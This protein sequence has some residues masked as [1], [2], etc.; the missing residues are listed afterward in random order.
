MEPIYPRGLPLEFLA[1]ATRYLDVRF[2]LTL[3]ALAPLAVAAASAQTNLERVVNGAFTPT[4]DYDLVHQRI[5][6]GNFDWDSTSFDGR[7]TT[8]VVSRRPGLDAV[9]LDMER[10]LE[11]RSVTAAGKAVAYDRPADSLVVRLARPAG[12]GDTLRFTVSY[13]ARIVQGRGLYFFKEEPGRARRPQQVY[14]GGGTD[15]N[16]RWIPTYG[17]PNDKATWEVIAT[18]P[19]RLTVVS[20]GRMVSERRVAGGLRTTH[21]WPPRW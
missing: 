1:H 2:S 20:N 4:H 19:A 14:S 16:P 13:H 3:A 21:W 5:E 7:V 11:V 17:A 8:T 18:V 12:F 6:V 9:V 15:G 10:R